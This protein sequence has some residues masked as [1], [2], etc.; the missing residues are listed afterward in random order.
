MRI[1]AEV[2]AGDILADSLDTTY[3]FFHE[4]GSDL[5]MLVVG[6]LLLPMV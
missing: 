5:I 2:K 1:G 6:I 3:L 4:H